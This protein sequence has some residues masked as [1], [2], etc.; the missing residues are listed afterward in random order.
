MINIIDK[1]ISKKNIIINNNNIFINYE[2]NFLNSDESIAFLGPLYSYSHLAVLTYIDNFFINKKIINVS[3]KSFFEIFF[4]IK[5]D[6]V[7]LAVVPIY[8]NITGVITE[9]SKLLEINST[10]LYIKKNFKLPVKHCLVSNK[11]IFFKK[12]KKIYSHSEPL[13]QCSIFIKK[14][15]SWELKY[16]SSTSF[17]MHLI[18]NSSSK[19]KLAAI[20]NE[21]AAN[22]YKLHILKK[23]ISN[24]KNNKTI[25]LVLKKH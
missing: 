22:F 1:N 23:N 25:F 20:G 5:Q 9:V 4:Y 2:S 7:K 8:N 18:K 12:I 17:A 13:K 3:C 19:E 24:K 21:T 14:N 16:C 11:K 10:Y 15:L 6:F